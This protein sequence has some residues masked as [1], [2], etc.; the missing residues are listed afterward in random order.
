MIQTKEHHQKTDQPAHERKFDQQSDDDDAQNKGPDLVLCQRRVEASQDPLAAQPCHYDLGQE[1]GYQDKSDHGCE[2]RQNGYPYD[3]SANSTEGDDAENNRA[4]YGNCDQEEEGEEESD[5]RH[6]APAEACRRLCLQFIRQGLHEGGGKPAKQQPEQDQCNDGAQQV[7]RPRNGFFCLCWLRFG[8]FN[9]Q[10]RLIACD[11]AFHDAAGN[12]GILGQRVDQ[13]AFDPGVFIDLQPRFHTRD[14]NFGIVDVHGRRRTV[15]VHI[16]NIHTDI[17]AE[18]A[19]QACSSRTDH[20]II[21]DIP[22]KKDLPAAIQQVAAHRAARFGFKAG[23]P[24]EQV[25]ANTGFVTQFQR[26][27]THA[28]IVHYGSVDDDTVP[29]CKQVTFHHPI[30]DDHISNDEQVTLDRSLQGEFLR[31]DV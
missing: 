19:A 12:G 30:D 10:Y 26:R 25:A 7:Q 15:L 1:N 17:A 3:G 24:G 31:T 21:G 28:D 14:G 27:A 16:S 23:A 2:Q 5:I 4:K 29:A 6:H 9:I 22:G 8:V 13:V 20:G 18:F 11:L